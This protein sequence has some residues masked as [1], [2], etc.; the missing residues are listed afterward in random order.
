MA[1]LEAAWTVNR[2]IGRLSPSCVKL[3]KSFQQ[4]FNP[5]MAGYFGLRPK[6][7]G[8]VYHNNIVST[9]KTPLHFTHWASV[10]AA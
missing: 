2:A 3:T 10:K 1:Q 4:A 6:L 7:G 5:K 9:L 8:H